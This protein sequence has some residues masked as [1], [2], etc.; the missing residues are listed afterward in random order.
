MS[1]SESVA[2]VTGGASGIGLAFVRAYAE[3]GAHVVIGDIDE[4]AM[5]QVRVGL[6]EQGARIDCVRVDLQ[7]AG[8]VAELGEVAAAFGPLGAVCLN[9]GVTSTGSTVWETADATYDFVVGVNL[10][11]LF[12]SIK[13]FVP[14]LVAQGH[15]A[16]VVITASMAGMVASPYSAVYAASKAGAIALAKSLHAELAIVAPSIRVALLNPGMVKTNLIRTSAARLPADASISDE[17]V[18]GMHD[19]LNQAGVEPDVAVSWALRALEDGTFWALPAAGD[20]FA[21]MLD[22]ELA[23]LHAV[24]SA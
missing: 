9:A 22:S 23:E 15:A 20:P 11:G 10:L 17:L 16:D 6:S 8:S 7:D 2:V 13:T 4:S 19:A 12:H 14:R 24:T 18:G 5:D 21:T 3:R 1:N